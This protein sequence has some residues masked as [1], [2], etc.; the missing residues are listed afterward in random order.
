MKKDFVNRFHIQGYCPSSV[1]IGLW[2]EARLVAVM[3]FTKP[4][5]AKGFRNKDGWELSRYCTNGSIVGGAGKLLK[6]FIKQYN[7]SSIITYADRRWSM[8]EL[9][10]KLGF[11]LSHISRPNY[12]YIKDDIRI[13]RFRLRKTP[14]D[15]PHLTEV[16]N[17]RK[18][19]YIRIHDCGNLCFHMKCNLDNMS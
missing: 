11:D 1:K 9:Y 16:E 13:H 6:A 7:P 2:H 17:R 3:T 14:N 4:N 15:D 8:G 10:E 19:G 18:Q 12:W 5:L